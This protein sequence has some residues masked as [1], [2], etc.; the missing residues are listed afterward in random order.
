LKEVQSMTAMPAIGFHKARKKPSGKYEAQWAEWVPELGK[1]KLSAK[2]FSLESSAEQYA[3]DEAEKN[4]EVATG[5]R[6]A[7]VPI[8]VALDKFFMRSETEQITVDLY[9]RHFD[10]FIARHE[11]KW[12]HQLMDVLPDKEFQWLKKFGDRGRPASRGGINHKFRLWKTFTGFCV[13]KTWLAKSPFPR[14]FKLPKSTFIGRPL[15]ED[16]FDSMI[17]IRA[18]PAYLEVDTWLRRWLI[19][20]RY[21]MARIE[22]IFELEPES[23]RNDG[24]EMLIPLIKHQDP[25]WSEITHPLALSVVQEL[26]NGAPRGQRLF[27]LWPT[28]GRMRGVF[29]RK[30]AKLGLKDVGPL[31]PHDA[32]KVTQVTA[33]D[34]LGMSPGEIAAVSNTTMETIM[35]HYIKPHRKNAFS[36][37]RALYA[38]VQT[39]HR[40]QEGYLRGILGDNR[41][42]SVTDG[43]GENSA[44][45][46][47]K[48]V[49]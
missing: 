34:G 46:D 14:K 24:T 2:T 30:A 25:V 4:E 49:V 32:C 11:L 23:F 45:I 16:E 8:E 43:N 12:V 22:T 44:S 21:T 36:K 42:Q 1:C 26:L 29:A 10:D 18:Q 47:G 13:D 39:T 27:S 37:V 31:R 17:A 33:L 38:E 48:T 40:P 15:S 19:L 20:Q 41:A 7:E 5:K 6:A 28:M 3:R 9:R 35:K